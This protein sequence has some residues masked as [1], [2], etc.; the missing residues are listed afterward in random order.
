MVMI[1]FGYFLCLIVGMIWGIDDLKIEML[2]S[3]G[4]LCIGLL[5]LVYDKLL[6]IV[7]M[8]ILCM[9]FWLFFNKIML[10]IVMWVS[11]ENMFVVYY[12]GIFVKCVVLI[13]WVI[14]VVVVIC[15]GV[16]LVLIIFI[17]F[18]VGF[19]FGLKVFFVVVFGGFGFIL[20]VVVGGVFIGVIESMVG[21]YLLEGWKDVVFYLVLFMV[22]LL[23][24]E[25]LFGQYVCKKV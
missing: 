13:V 10:G 24:F 12:M 4:V 16:L 15:V 3:Q 19:V 6:V 17:Y 22:L 20:G 18:N 8:M 23:K 7:V 14:S 25:G 21:F 1:G 5:V 11:F 9:L 2:F